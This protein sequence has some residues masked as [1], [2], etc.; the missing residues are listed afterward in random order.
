M[1]RRGFHPTNHR[2]VIELL[3]PMGDW[4]DSV[5]TNHR[6]IHWMS[7][8]NG[9]RVVL[10]GANKIRICIYSS[11]FRWDLFFLSFLVDSSNECAGKAHAKTR[12]IWGLLQSAQI[13]SWCWP[14]H[15]HQFSRAGKGEL[16]LKSTVAKQR[17]VLSIT[18]FPFILQIKEEF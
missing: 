13:L 5:T 17:R 18:K 14:V 16:F 6:T 12:R 4:V 1:D 9:R 11:L 15:V 10:T 2:R 3:K 8:A 7:Q